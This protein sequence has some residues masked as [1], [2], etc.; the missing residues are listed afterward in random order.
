MNRIYSLCLPAALGVLMLGQVSL[1][2]AADL[3]KNA[4]GGG[5]VAAA[6]HAAAP[7][8]VA[9]R[10]A[11]G[12]FSAARMQQ[13]SFAARPVGL[14]NRS[15]AQHRSIQQTRPVAQTRTFNRT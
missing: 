9:A 12:G 13:R 8:R 1:A 2:N 7:A 4:N 11:G 3:R 6:P 14:S 5:R 10:P 15:F